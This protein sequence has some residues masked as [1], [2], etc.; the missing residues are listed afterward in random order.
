MN[1]K[2]EEYWQS[3]HGERQVKGFLKRS[4]AK[5]TGELLSLSR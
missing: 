4:S 3:I 5:R 1:R 2:D